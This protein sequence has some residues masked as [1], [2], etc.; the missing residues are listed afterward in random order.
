MLA[1]FSKLNIRILTERADKKGQRKINVDGKEISV[2][3]E[4]D[5]IC[6]VILLLPKKIISSFNF[7]LL[8]FIQ[9]VISAMQCSNLFIK[10][11][12]SFG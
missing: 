12:R 5:G 7:N 1:I 2:C 4:G 11:E 8:T 9:V 3:I 6:F 10:P